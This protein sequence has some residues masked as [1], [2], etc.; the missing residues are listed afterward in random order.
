MSTGN[1]ARGKEV[2]LLSDELY[3]VSAIT[4]GYTDVDVTDDCIRITAVDDGTAYFKID[5]GAMY[6]IY[7]VIIYHYNNNRK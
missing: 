5:L 1:V 2:S 4:N 6:R 7:S 3:A